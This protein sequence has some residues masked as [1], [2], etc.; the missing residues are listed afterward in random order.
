MAAAYD[1]FDYP[2]YWIG[3][4][5]EHKSEVQALK[6]F[7]KKIHRVKKILEVGA[8]F[9]RLAKYYFYRGKQIILSDPSSKLLKVARETYKDK[10]NFK[11]IHSSLENLPNKLRNKSVDLVILVRVTHHLEDIEESIKI[12]SKLL[13]TGGYF[14]FEFP[15]KSNYKA[16]FK[17]LIKGDITYPLNIFSKD[18][19]SKKSLRTNAL[20]FYNYHPDKMIELLTD[21]NFKIIDVLS[22]SNFRS[23][24]IK[25]YIST[26]SL[27]YLESKLQKLFS[28]LYFGPSIFIL[29]RKLPS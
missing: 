22:V 8:G 3:R 11:F 28:Y 18:I 9:G 4:E 1:N 12:I 13:S 25:K 27:V 26:D 5:Y 24:R 16:V 29:A 20:P 23:S 19:R 17:N 7:F 21:N 6:N 14:I 2:A 15:N 10:K